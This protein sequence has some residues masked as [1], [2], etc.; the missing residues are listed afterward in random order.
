MSG[1]SR[2]PVLIQA[3]SHLSERYYSF[4]FYWPA[5]YLLKFQMRVLPKSIDGQSP[6]PSSGDSSGG[7]VFTWDSGPASCLEA[8]GRGRGGIWSPVEVFEDSVFSCSWSPDLTRVSKEGMSR[9]WP[10]S[11]SICPEELPLQ[12]LCMDCRKDSF[13]FF[14]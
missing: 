6:R 9:R 10:A 8:P 4:S 12:T 1:G 2:S 13:L 14:F 11:P 3:V 5:G 7:C